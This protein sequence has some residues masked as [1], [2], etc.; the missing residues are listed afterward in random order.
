MLITREKF[1]EATGREPI[2]DDLDRCNCP[3][4]GKLGH[5]SCGWNIEH[6]KPQF[7]VGPRMRDIQEEM[8][9]IAQRSTPRRNNDR[10]T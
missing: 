4:A 10:Q 2:N 5:W 8:N 9:D 1:I 6:D 3:E 7:M